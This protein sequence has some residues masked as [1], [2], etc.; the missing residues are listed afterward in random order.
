M[1]RG[2]PARVGQVHT[3]SVIQEKPIARMAT[4]PQR[5]PAKATGA[6]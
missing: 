5:I 1:W 6:R 3:I 4:T 2:R